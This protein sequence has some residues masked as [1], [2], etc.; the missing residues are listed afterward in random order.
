M[1]RDPFAALGLAASRDLT[2]DDVR[3]AWRRVAAATHPD[4]ADGGDPAAFAAA[5]SAYSDL[6]TRF[7]RNEALADLRTTARRP[8]PAARWAPRARPALARSAPGRG[9]A[10]ADRSGRVGCGAGRTG[11]RRPWRSALAGPGTAS[12]AL[13]GPGTAS[14]ALRLGRASP[15][16][17]AGPAGAAGGGRRRGKRAGRG[18]RR[19]AAGHARTDGRGPDLALP[20]RPPG[21]GPPPGTW[22]PTSPAHPADRMITDVRQ[23]YH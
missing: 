23:R 20:H 19:L 7:G 21:P 5:A 16:R 17:T 12:L 9:V 2:D 10:G 6:R 22:P 4:R 14:L 11:A 15:A 3:A 8:R 13:A 18:D 1:T